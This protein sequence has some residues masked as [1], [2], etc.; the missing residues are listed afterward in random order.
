AEVVAGEGEA[1]AERLRTRLRS[2]VVERLGWHRERGDEVVIVSA[3]LAV[4]LE[5]L[6]RTLGATAVLATGLEVCPDGRLT[7]RLEGANVRGAEKAARLR[8]YLAGERCEL[9]AYGDSR[10]DRE[11]L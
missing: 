9:W 11:L 3:S 4:Y 10:G 8:G 1:F 2:D 5:P 6:G 7:G